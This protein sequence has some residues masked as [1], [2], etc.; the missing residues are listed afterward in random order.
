MV[1]A[2]SLRNLFDRKIF[3]EFGLTVTWYKKTDG[4]DWGDTQ[5]PDYDGGTNITAVPYDT[6]SQRMSFEQLGQLE[7]GETRFAVRY[8][9]DVQQD[10][11]LAFDSKEY[12]VQEVEDNYLQK[13]LIKI[14]TAARI[15]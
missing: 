10:D 4:H 7:S 2:D 9:K 13:N 12:E 3:D 14:V 11:K 1:S 5:N 6:F 8:D 15:S